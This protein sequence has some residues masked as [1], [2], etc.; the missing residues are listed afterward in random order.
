MLRQLLHAGREP[1]NLDLR[2]AAVAAVALKGRDLGQV[3]A[4]A[5][6]AR[7]AESSGHK[8]TR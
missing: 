6:V 3:G 4:L 2:A 8:E 7:T 1:R 5:A